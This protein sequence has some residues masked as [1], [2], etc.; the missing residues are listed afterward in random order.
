MAGIEPGA[1]PQRVRAVNGRLPV[2]ARVPPQGKSGRRDLN[3]R[4][5]APE[6]PA[7]YQAFLRPVH[8]SDHR[9]RCPELNP[10][11]RHGKAAG[12]RYIMGA[13]GMP[14]CQRT[15]STGPLPRCPDSNPRRR[16]T[17][18]VSSP[19]D[20][21]CFSVGPDGLEPSPPWL[22]ARHAAASTLIPSSAFLPSRRSRR[23]GSRTL[24]LALIRGPL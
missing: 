15:K 22:R 2:P 9:S 10:H 14:D 13:C 18:A 12:Y 11:F 3:P 4:S 7:E 16:I 6:S 23:G 8:Q 20:D 5:R 24:G 21:Q 1:P 17:G 19:L